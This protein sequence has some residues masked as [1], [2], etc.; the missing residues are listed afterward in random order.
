MSS[1]DLVKVFEG[2]AYQSLCPNRIW[3]AWQANSRYN[4]RSQLLNLLKE[5]GA[6]LK[7]ALKH[8]DHSMCNFDFCEFSSRN[9]TAVQQY[10]ERRPYEEEEQT[11]V[12]ENHKKRDVCFPLHGLFKDKIL[13]EAVYSNDLTAWCLD[14][15][16]I[17]EHH[18]PFMA[19]SHVWSDGTGTGTWPSKQ[20]NECL[21]GYFRGVAE[22]FQC[23]GIWW[24][25]LCV[26]Q[27]R[28]VRGDALNV[29]HRNYEY[30]RLTLVHDRFL[31]NLPFERP[32]QACLAIVM[33]PWFTRGW[34]AL[35]LAKSRKVKIVFK[36]SIKDLDEDILRKINEV[37][38]AAEVIKTLRKDQISGI[39]DL[40]VTLG[41]RYTSWLKDRA[42]IAGL[43]TGIPIPDSN[44]DTFQRD[45]YQS[46]LIKLQKVSHHHLF[47]NSVTMS[48]GFSWCPTSLFQ[49]PRTP[50]HHRHK[51]PASAPELTVNENGEVVGSWKPFRLKEIKQDMCVWGYSHELI[52]AK[53]R[54]ALEN[55]KHH[56][57]VVP[58]KEESCGEGIKKGLLV[59]VLKN[60]RDG[61]PKVKCR[62]VGSLYFHSALT[63]EGSAAREMTIGDTEGWRLLEENEDAW[64]MIK[65]MEREKDAVPEEPKRKVEGN[66]G[67]R[68]L[69]SKPGPEHP[70]VRRYE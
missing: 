27:E 19:I 34:T 45:L 63:V 60:P 56:L 17:L 22:R 8:E 48:K 5:F 44:R 12:A 1:A 52:E 30:A 21:Y 32:E 29:M 10:H 9:F 42:A 66:S 7:D 38:D 40:L 18:R 20:V 16:D 35:E 14:G 67:L 23:E 50:D 62:F 61:K 49:L 26:P 51:T 69:E 33:S 37:N 65:K 54:G 36:D 55:K 25:T 11:K 43:L 24:D 41:P 47:H 59:K 4:L 57:L 28:N 46:I 58:P 39:E 70:L 53:L 64:D 2:G 15:S 3:Q 6:T 68:T 13:V 31:R